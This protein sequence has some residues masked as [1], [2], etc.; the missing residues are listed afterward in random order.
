MQMTICHGCGEEL[1]CRNCGDLFK[2]RR[3]DGAGTYV[4]P[5]TPLNEKEAW[6]LTFIRAFS[7]PMDRHKIQDLIYPKGVPH[8][9]LPKGWSDHVIQVTLSTLVGRKL[10]Y[11][12]AKQ[13]PPTY[14]ALPSKPLEE[15]Y[16]SA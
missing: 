11:M 12:D 15:S 2:G 1:R 3:P 13:N 7:V 9:T 5:G 14:R 10:V 16:R 6:L 4:P 8:E